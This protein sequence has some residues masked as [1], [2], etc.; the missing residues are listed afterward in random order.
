MIGPSFGTELAAAGLLGLP[1]AWDANGVTPGVALSEADRARLD[2][3]VAA[4][5]PTRAEPVD[6]GAI[7]DA[8]RDRR[9]PLGLTYQGHA[10]QTRP[11][12]IDN[13]TGAATAAVAAI[14]AGAQPGDLRWA[15]PDV[16]FGWIATDNTVVPMDA[17]TL[18]GLARAAMARRSALIRAGRALK[19]QLAGNPDLDV[20]A[21]TLWPA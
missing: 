19:D 13:L 3:V 5:D 7:V 12:D 15:D 4:H 9:L 10:Y 17:P 14:A 21:D 11:F 18:F 6:R 2:A 8:E 20:T 16:D 1:F